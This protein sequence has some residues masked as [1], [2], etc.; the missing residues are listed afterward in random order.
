MNPID[1]ASH[2]PVI[3]VI[4][5][6]RVEDALPLAEALPGFRLQ[7]R[8]GSATPT[9]RQLMTHHAGLPRDHA[10]GMW[11]D[12][13]QK[14]PTLA[15]RVQSLNDTE[16]A[17]PAGQLFSYSNVGLTLLGAV[18]ERAAGRP[19]E[20]Q[21]QQQHEKQQQQHQNN[22]THFVS[23]IEDQHKIQRALAHFARN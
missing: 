8:E 18:V 6:D 2:G 20:Q 10:A 17:Y 23:L 7:P 9:L 14:P 21:L 13:T 5:I 4:V 11:F 12:A 3:P 22:S 1:I 15:E 19:F 16:A